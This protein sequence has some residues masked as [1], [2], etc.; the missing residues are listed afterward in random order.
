MARNICGCDF[1][2][3]SFF[4]A[5]VNFFAILIFAFSPA[6][7]Y[8]TDHAPYSLHIHVVHVHIHCHISLLY[9]H[10][11]NPTW[12][13]SR[14][15]QKEVFCCRK[16]TVE[17]HHRNMLLACVKICTRQNFDKF[18]RSHF[19]Y[20]CLHCRHKKVLNHVKI[21]CYTVHP[22]FYLGFGSKVIN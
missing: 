8:L 17:S 10:G 6:N 9:G 15:T 21:S 4:L 2:K 12:Q 19:L 16:I 14:R 13:S 22:G 5:V 18:K 7:W 3:I 11:T 1:S 20:W